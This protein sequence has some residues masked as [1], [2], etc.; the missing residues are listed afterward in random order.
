MKI[1]DPLGHAS[2]G[3]VRYADIT[4]AAAAALIRVQNESVATLRPARAI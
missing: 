3:C 1:N 2:Y 4:L